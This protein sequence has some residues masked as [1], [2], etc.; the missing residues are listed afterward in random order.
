MENQKIINFNTIKLVEINNESRGT[1]NVSNQIKFKTSMIRSHLCDYSDAYIHVKETITVPNT[2]TA[3]APNNRNKKVIFRN[4]AL[5]TNR[6]KDINNT[7][8]DDAHDNDVV[9]AMYNLI[10]YSDVYLKTSGSL[11][12]YNGDESALNKNGNIIDFP[13]NNNNSISFKFKQKRTG[14]TGNNRTKDIEIKVSL[15]YLSNFWGIFEMPSINCEI[16][17]ILQWTSTWT[18]FN[19][20]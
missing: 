18:C 7:Q 5:F 16:S 19:A 12:Q 1:L 13:N 20:L 4:C 6:I 14:K 3:A 11:L 10:E 2:R 17:P 15:K 9:M 8:V